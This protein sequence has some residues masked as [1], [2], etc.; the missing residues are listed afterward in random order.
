MPR[1]V[2]HVRHT[3][4]KGTTVQFREPNGQHYSGGQLV[5]CPDAPT[6]KLTEALKAVRTAMLRRS[7][8]DGETFADAFVLTGIDVT[9]DGKGRRK[10]KP[11]CAISFGWGPAVHQSLPTVLE[12]V[13]DADEDGE[14]RLTELE[15]KKVDALLDAALEYY[16]GARIVEQPELDE[17]AEG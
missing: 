13:D 8:I 15:Q 11:A 12:Y 17:A 7:V 14:T 16:D 9:Y 5:A 2:T 1:E 3:S 6:A 10:F 4:Q